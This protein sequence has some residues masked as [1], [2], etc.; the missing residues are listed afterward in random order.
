MMSIDSI[1]YLESYHELFK[2][3]R[4]DTNFVNISENS[5]TSFAV[6]QAHWAPLFFS[7]MAGFYSGKDA[8]QTNP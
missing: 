8:R 3:Q 7:T 1:V 4:V 6:L 5:A 2:S